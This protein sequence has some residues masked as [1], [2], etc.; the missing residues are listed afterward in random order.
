MAVVFT[1]HEASCRFEEL[2]DRALAGEDVSIERDNGFKVRIVPLS[3]EEARAVL[4][5]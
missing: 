2:L 1:E 4:T 3:D 5:R